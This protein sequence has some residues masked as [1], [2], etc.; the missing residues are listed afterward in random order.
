MLFSKNDIDLSSTSMSD[1]EMAT[2][3]NT[4]TSTAD[5]SDGNFSKRLS[6]YRK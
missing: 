3:E 5:A 4:C 6:L 1:S 2:V